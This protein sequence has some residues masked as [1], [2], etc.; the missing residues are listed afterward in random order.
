MSPQSRIISKNKRKASEQVFLFFCDIFKKGLL[1]QG[2]IKLENSLVDV[3]FVVMPK[4]LLS[5][6]GKILIMRYEKVTKS[7]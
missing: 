2:I 4:I 6:L 3:I 7:V 1:G 5:R